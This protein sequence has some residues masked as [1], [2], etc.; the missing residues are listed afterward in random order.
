MTS[1][2]AAPYDEFV[3]TTGEEL[4]DRI[5][6]AHRRFAALLSVTPHRTPIADS[7]WTAGEVAGHV[8]TVLRRYTGDHPGGL[9]P[10]AAGVAGL[11]AIELEELGS[12]SV[13]EILDLLWQELADVEA[14]HPRSLDLHE[15][16]AFHGD[17]R[18]DGAGLLGNLL[19]EFLIHGRDVARARGKQ[20][21]IGGRNAALAMTAS[22]QAA[23]GFLHPAAPGDLRVE[24]RT[25][26]TNPWILDLA[27]G[28]LTSRRA[29]GREPVDV[30]VYT[31]AQ[32]LLLQT[33]GRIGLAGTAAR[34]V[35]V[36]GGRRPWRITRLPRT[37]Q[38][39]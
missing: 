16:F 26:E 21:K 32:P 10:D 17:Q 24:I 14:K 37:F 5:H 33:Y 25:P 39:P 22:L 6:Q 35:L 31:R 29:E 18:L 36:I 3:R 4:W 23:P 9:K 28:A 38:T 7:D 13:A 15:T 11:N 8:L 27:E 19:G 12:L 20:W 34:G 30:R 2:G 1:S